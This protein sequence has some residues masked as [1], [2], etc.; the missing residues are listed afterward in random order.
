M[1]DPT[2]LE[3]DPA[4]NSR[5]RLFI[6]AGVGAA[7]ALLGLVVLPMLSGGGGGTAEPIAAPRRVTAEPKATGR[8]KPIET[9]ASFA[10][11]DPFKP[12]IAVAAA[13]GGT[14]APAAA[15]PAPAPIGTLSLVGTASPA[16]APLPA[17]PVAAASSPTLS[18]APAATPAHTPAP[19]PAT[20]P[21]T[22]APTTSTTAAPPTATEPRAGRAIALLEVVPAD[23]GPSAT[24]RVDGTVYEG[25]H[26]GDVFAGS[27][28]VVSL[29][30]S[31]GTFL[32]GDD[33]FTLCVGEEV[34]K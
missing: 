23:S 12:L 14:P 29:T 7:L 15:A 21:T 28:K 30:S 24:V 22:S 27:F 32:Y 19:A 10:D 16:P 9:V 25:A 3:L 2:P 5:R 20:T 4:P 34:V 17:A 26:A 31:C 1:T 33:S 11:R 18:P 8:A 6:L 13:P